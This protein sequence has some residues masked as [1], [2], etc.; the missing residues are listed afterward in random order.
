V[1]SIDFSVLDLPS[2]SGSSSSSSS[3]VTS[4]LSNMANGKEKSLPSFWVPSQ[5][6]DPVKIKLNMPDPTILCPVSGKP[7]KIK[8]LIDVKFHL[9]DEKADKKTLISQE[10]RYKC[11]VSSDVLTNAVPL[12]V[13]RTTGDVVTMEVVEKII[14]VDWIH[15]LTNAK[16]TERDIIPLQRGGTGFASANDSLQASTS[17]PAQQC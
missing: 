12:A 5:T 3:T 4:T 10:T 1:T 9:I 17:R 13:I 6:P 16:L 7:M 14:K 8:D 11:A 2:G 15:P